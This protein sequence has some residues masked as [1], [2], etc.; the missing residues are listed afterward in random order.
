MPDNTEEVVARVYEQYRRGDPIS[1]TDLQIA[2]PYFSD[3]AKRLA[4][5]GPRLSLAH[6]DILQISLGLRR[7]IQARSEIG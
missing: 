4:P 6:D 2:A 5:L 7:F 1:D 3:L